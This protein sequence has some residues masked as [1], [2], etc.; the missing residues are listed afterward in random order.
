MTR[1]QHCSMIKAQSYI[2]D[3][4]TWPSYLKEI[5]VQCLRMSQSDAVTKTGSYSLLNKRFANCFLC[6]RP[7]NF[8]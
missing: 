5:Q 4:K 2:E 3:Y 7:W 1:D 6:K 8:P